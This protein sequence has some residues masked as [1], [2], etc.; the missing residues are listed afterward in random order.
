MKIKQLKR[1]CVFMGSPG[2]KGGSR[3]S[4]EHIF[5]QWMHDLVEHPDQNWHIDQ[6]GIPEKRPLLENRR[7]PGLTIHRTVRI[8]KSCNEGWMR[9]VEDEARPTLTPIIVGRATQL[10]EDQQVTI[11]KWLT[12]KAITAEYSDLK[13]VAVTTAERDEFFGTRTPLAK[14]QIYI[15]HYRGED[16]KSRYHHYTYYLSE[17]GIHPPRGSR[18]IN[19]QLTI[20][21]YGN[22]FSFSVSNLRAGAF[23]FPDWFRQLMA[24][25]WPIKSPLVTMPVTVISDRDAD[26]IMN[27]MPSFIRQLPPRNRAG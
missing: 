11:A 19:A 26:D 9:D 25:I 12:M 16:W 17:G 22:L 23:E 7:A 3:I 20:L 5:S 1:D 21:S 24:R 2:H 14:W 4:K 18:P 10:S 27:F 8:C 15:G 13:N 6:R